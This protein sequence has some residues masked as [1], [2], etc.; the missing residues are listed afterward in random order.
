[1][2]HAN[3][4]NGFTLEILACLDAIRRSPSPIADACITW[5]RQKFR[6]TRWH[7]SLAVIVR[8]FFANSGAMRSKTQ[9]SPRPPFHAEVNILYRPDVVAERK[10]FGYW[11]AISSSFEGWRIFHG[12]PTGFVVKIPLG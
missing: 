6:S 1:V 2:R 11:H 9:A 5:W 3:E 8:P 12:R 10:Q 7:V 4:F